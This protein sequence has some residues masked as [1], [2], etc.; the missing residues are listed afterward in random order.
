MWLCVMYGAGV[1]AIFKTMKAIAWCMV[2]ASLASAPALFLN[3]TGD[4]NAIGALQAAPV[5]R[6]DSHLFITT[7]GS[8]GDVSNITSLRLTIPGT[9]CESAAAN[10]NTTASTFIGILP[11]TVDKATVANLYSA[12]AATTA[13]LVRDAI[14]PF[15]RGPR[16]PCNSSSCT[17]CV[18]HVPT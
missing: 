17:L 2:F 5:V 6:T 1:T 4:P 15:S 9:D 18:A 14:L 13:V 12:I 8:I 16:Q 7:M 3:I 11:C 10:S